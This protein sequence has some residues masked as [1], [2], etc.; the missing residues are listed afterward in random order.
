[1][2]FTREQLAYE[3]FVAGIKANHATEKNKD[4]DT[5]ISDRTPIPDFDTCEFFPTIED[6]KKARRMLRA[7][8]HSPTVDRAVRNVADRRAVLPKVLAF[9]RE[10]Q[11]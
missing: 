11:E 5:R 2:K 4:P 7:G 3:E 10:F 1:M 8:R 6:Q 9:I